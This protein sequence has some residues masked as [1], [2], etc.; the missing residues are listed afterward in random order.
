V[1]HFT[2]TLIAHGTHGH[3]QK[4]VSEALVRLERPKLKAEAREGKQFLGRG[5][6]G[7]LGERCKLT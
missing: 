7:V 1:E 3:S 2:A 4:L 5:Q 6:L